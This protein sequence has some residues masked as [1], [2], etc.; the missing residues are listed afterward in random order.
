MGSIANSFRSLMTRYGFWTDIHR[1]LSDG[2][3]IRVRVRVMRR[4]ADQDPLIHEVDQ[5]TTWYR[6]RIDELKSAGFPLP[7]R[8]GDRI[9]EDGIYY[10]CFIAEPLRDGPNIIGYLMR[11]QGDT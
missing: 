5:V 10:T 6:V 11:C 8:N 1:V 3:D 2:G 9:L 7:V 4:Y